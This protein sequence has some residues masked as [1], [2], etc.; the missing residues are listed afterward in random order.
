MSFAAIARRTGESQRAVA[1]T[2]PRGTDAILRQLPDYADYSE[3]R[4]CLRCLKPGTGTVDAPKGFGLMLKDKL[5]NDGPV[6][7][8]TSVYP[9]LYMRFHNGALVGLIATH[10]D[11][12]SNVEA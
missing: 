12:L 2:L 5:E 9:E 4:Y 7:V 11:D 1:F 8:A 10:V 6:W 3:D